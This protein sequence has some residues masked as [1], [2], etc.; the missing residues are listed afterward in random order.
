MGGKMAKKTRALIRDREKLARLSP[1][2]SAE[3]PWAIDSASAIEPR[4]RSLRCPQCAGEYRLGEH[5]SPAEALRRIDVTCRTCHAP[6][7]LWFRLGSSLP[8]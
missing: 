6:R 7:S 5:T 4:V 1:G 8:S 2:G 3:R